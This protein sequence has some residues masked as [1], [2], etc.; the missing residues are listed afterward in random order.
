MLYLSK[1]T[2]TKNGVKLEWNWTE[3]IDVGLKSVHTDI[4]SLSAFPLT[5]LS[6][7]FD[8]HGPLLAGGVSRGDGDQVGGIWL[9][10]PEH[11][12]VLCPPECDGIEPTP[13]QRRVF[14]VVTC[15]PLGLK[16]PP[17]DPDTGGARLG[18]SYSGRTQH[19]WTETSQRHRQ[20]IWSEEII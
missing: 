15:D 2:I 13:G 1:S 12:G 16:G 17:A 11:G 10:V 19:V 4:W 6:A 8:R 14:N 9:E 18:D 7:H 3:R 20:Y 5:F